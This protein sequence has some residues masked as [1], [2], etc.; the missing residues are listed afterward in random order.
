[1]TTWSLWSFPNELEK[2]LSSGKFEEVRIEQTLEYPNGEPGF[3]FIRLRYVENIDA[4]LDAERGGPP[5]AL[6]RDQPATSTVSGAG[7]LLDAG[8]GQHRAA[9]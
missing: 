7:A 3:Y 2:V 1:M 4:I 8:H 9:L 5:R 6:L